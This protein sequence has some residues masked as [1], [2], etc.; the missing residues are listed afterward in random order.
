MYPW[1]IIFL[2]ILSTDESAFIHLNAEVAVILP[3]FCLATLC[4]QNKNREKGEEKER[5]SKW[6]S[7]RVS[8]QWAP[9]LVGLIRDETSQ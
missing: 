7:E 1:L 5:E 6:E 8:D 9:S 2:K 4:W 3:A